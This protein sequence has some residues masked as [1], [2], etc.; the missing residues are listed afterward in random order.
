[1]STDP[2]TVLSP[3]ISQMFP[4]FLLLGAVSVLGVLF[5]VFKPRI[6]GWLGENAVERL[7]ENELDPSI[8]LRHS[9]IMLPVAGDTTQIDHVVVS[10]FGVFVIETK[11]YNGWIFGN[12]ND[13]QWTKTMYREKYRFQNPLHQNA[14]HVRVLSDLT[15]VPK[16]FF[17][18]IV[19]F[20]RGAEFKTAMLENVRHTY[21]LAAYI[22][23]HQKTLLPDDRVRAVIEH[24]QKKAATVSAEMKANHIANLRKRH[25][26]R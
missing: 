24:I 10:R 12:P 8:Y 22:H 20:L 17:K 13:A 23:G 2:N 14:G 19:V 3:M 26:G 18:S 16:E 6:K 5:Q 9:N 25:G 1:M 7:L 21:D 15:G 4:L 11:N